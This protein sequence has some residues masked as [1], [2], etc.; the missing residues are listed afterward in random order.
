MC[1]SSEPFFLLHLPLLHCRTIIAWL[2][3]SVS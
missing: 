3:Q 1:L 2:R